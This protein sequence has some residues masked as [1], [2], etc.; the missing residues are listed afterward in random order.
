MNNSK[1]QLILHVHLDK[2]K[3]SAN[4]LKAL[5]YPLATVSTGKHNSPSVMPTAN[6]EIRL[7]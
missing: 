3:T 4:Y 7:H 5:Q 6:V 2:Q 1:L